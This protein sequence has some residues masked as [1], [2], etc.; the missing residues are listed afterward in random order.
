MSTNRDL[1]ALRAAV[2]YGNPIPADVTARLLA[3]GVDVGEVERRL[4]DT[5]AFSSP[6]ATETVN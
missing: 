3:A 2:N 5:L 4:I 6:S 1:R